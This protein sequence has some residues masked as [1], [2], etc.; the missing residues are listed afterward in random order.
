MSKCARSTC[1]TISESFVLCGRCQLVRYCSESCRIASRK[2]HAKVCIGTPTMGPLLTAVSGPAGPTEGNVVDVKKVTD[3]LGDKNKILHIVQSLLRSVPSA[4][5][6]IEEKGSATVSEREEIVSAPSAEDE[7]MPP[8]EGTPMDIFR[9]VMMFPT[10]D[11]KLSGTEEISTY[12]IDNCRTIFAQFREH[13]DK[14]DPGLVF[15]T[16][17]DDARAEMDKAIMKIF[18]YAEKEPSIRYI[19]KHHSLRNEVVKAHLATDLCICVL[20]HGIIQY[21]FIGDGVALLE[22]RE[23]EASSVADYVRDHLEVVTI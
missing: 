3:L 12:V 20:S 21:A 6:A 19:A 7:A 4:A 1:A 14:K 11:V 22:R 13:Y 16:R 5:P 15:C 9:Q 23:G 18:P 2:V 8:L 10:K 17:D